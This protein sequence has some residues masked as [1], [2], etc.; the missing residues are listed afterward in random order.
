[1][2]RTRRRPFTGSKRFDASCRSHGGCGWCEDNRKH[3]DR[4]HVPADEEQQVEYG[5]LGYD[6]EQLDEDLELMCHVFDE[7]EGR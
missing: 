1:M 3:R 4:K 5:Y 7:G 6:P 2:S